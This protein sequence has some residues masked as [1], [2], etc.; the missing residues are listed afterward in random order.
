MYI[1]GNEFCSLWLA[2]STPLQDFRHSTR[3]PFASY[4]TFGCQARRSL[5]ATQAFKRTV[6]FSDPS[7]LAKP[8]RNPTVASSRLDPTTT[9]L[10]HRQSR[11]S[12][13]QHF[14]ATSCFWN[15]FVLSKASRDQCVRSH[16][17]RRQLPD[18][19]PYTVTLK[20][21]GSPPE[22]HIR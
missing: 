4:C 12:F 20:I 14:N 22:H 19:A 5:R 21:H 3:T 16:D 10:L 13:L 11:P 2:R 9:D 6:S 1:R 18:R 8:L 17:D 15:R 7:V